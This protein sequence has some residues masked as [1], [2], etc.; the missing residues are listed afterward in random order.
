MPF[1]K[2]Y[3][4]RMRL[5]GLEYGSQHPTLESMR[6]ERRVLLQQNPIRH[7]VRFAASYGRS[8]DIEFADAMATITPRCF[9]QF[10]C[11][12]RSPP[13]A[14]IGK[15]A[16]LQESNSGGILRR[17]RGVGGSS[18]FVTMQ[19]FCTCLASYLNFKTSL[20]SKHSIDTCSMIGEWR[21]F[22][23]RRC[24]EEIW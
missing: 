8:F 9:N 21:I 3:C 15:E 16:S 17:A 12:A 22:I 24:S 4:R 10:V 5:K 14:S 20:Q 19:I 11:A 7:T 18:F 6:K 23:C 13:I 1:T 2:V